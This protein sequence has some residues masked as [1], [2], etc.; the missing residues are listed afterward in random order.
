[1]TKGAL[2][3]ILAVIFAIIL[4]L[5]ILLSSTQTEIFS[6]FQKFKNSDTKS[7]E[8]IVA[9]V[10]GENITK[11]HIDFIVEYKTLSNKNASQYERDNGL[12]V[13]AR[14]VDREEIIQQE[15]EKVVIWQETQ[16]Q[17]SVVDYDYAYNQ[18]KQI[19]ESSKSD[20]YVTE[21]L[22][23]Y[24]KANDLSEDE[25]IE[26]YAKSYQKQLSE[27]K[28]YE[29]ITENITESKEEYFR[30]YV[31]ELVKSSKIIRF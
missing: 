16:K 8:D 30:N 27:Q 17:K 29:K 26:L 12:D 23:E 13:K 20:E 3:K 5:F 1:M 7:N 18:A 19:Y 11:K 4:V 21:E 24:M 6:L 22:N 25:Y 28:L 15:I 10:N 14:T 31:D 2:L 9:T